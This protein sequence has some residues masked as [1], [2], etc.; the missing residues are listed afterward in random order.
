MYQWKVR[1]VLYRDRFFIFIITLSGWTPT[2]V[3]GLP[4]AIFWTSHGHRHSPRYVPS[5]VSRIRFSFPTAG[6][7]TSA[8]LLTHAL[9]L[10]ARHVSSKKTYLRVCTW[11]DS[12]PRNWSWAGTR[13]TYQATGHAGRLG[14]HEVSII[15]SMTLYNTEDGI[16]RLSSRHCKDARV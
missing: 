3:G 4:S 13:T 2:S 10:S 14:M 5:F 12:N 7:F 16:P 1:M 11:L 9:E 15:R 8:V 6:R